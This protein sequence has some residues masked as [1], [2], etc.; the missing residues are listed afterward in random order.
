[1]FPS[2]PSSS[3][4]SQRRW[5]IRALLV[6]DDEP[7]RELLCG[8]LARF[9]IE[10]RGVAD[11]A[12]MR[13]ALAEEN[14][15]VVVLDLMLPGEDGLSLCRYLRSESDI[16]ILMLT[17]RCEPADRIIGLELGADDYMAKPFE[18]RELVARIQTILR[19]V[20]GDEG[21]NEPRAQVRFDQWRLD[22]VLRQLHSPEGL[23]VPLSNAEFRLLWVFLERPRRVLNRELLLDAARGRAIE[24]FD[25]SIDLLVSRL[26]QKLGDDPRSPRLIKT[27]RG[28][29][30]L[31]DVR[32]IA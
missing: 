28:E 2:S 14:F 20:R 11:G 31:F 5:T 4:D 30:Y 10:A 19:R 18:P 22:S 25:R 27:V 3:Q 13:Q 26:R 7:I 29:G 1:M 32:D 24:A 16:P 12:G 17:A 23:V 21:R 8:Y 9:N 6:D 15:D